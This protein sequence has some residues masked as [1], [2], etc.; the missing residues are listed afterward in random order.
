MY[1][2]VQLTTKQFVDTFFIRWYEAG[3][4]NT[5]FLYKFVDKQNAHHL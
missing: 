2:I 5:F 4:N 1:I 3:L